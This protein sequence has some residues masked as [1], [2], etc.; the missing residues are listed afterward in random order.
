LP[1]SPKT[2]TQ[3]A[4]ET[5]ARKAAA[6]ALGLISNWWSPA[7]SEQDAKAIIH[8]RYPSLDATDIQTNYA[9]LLAQ[10]NGARLNVNRFTIAQVDEDGVEKAKLARGIFAEVRQEMTTVDYVAVLHKIAAGKITELRPLVAYGDVT[11]KTWLQ[12]LETKSIDSAQQMIGNG[13][14]IYEAV[15]ESHKTKEKK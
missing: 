2:S 15:Q 5:R 9:S 13:Q 11:D 6:F 8:E 4:A 3:R 1:P 7:L 14:G 10:A 12:N